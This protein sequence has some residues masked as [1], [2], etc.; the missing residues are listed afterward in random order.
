PQPWPISPPPTPTGSP[1]RCSPPTGESSPQ[2]AP[3]EAPRPRRCISSRLGDCPN[4]EVTVPEGRYRGWGRRRTRP[5]GTQR[6]REARRL[7]TSTCARGA[8][9]AETSA[10]NALPAALSHSPAEISSRAES[11]NGEQ[12][13][14]GLGNRRAGTHTLRPAIRISLTL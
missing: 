6:G 1:R 14:P 10:P 2:A 3:P 4:V 12:S 9:R 8:L 5:V 13:Q 11:V 7:S